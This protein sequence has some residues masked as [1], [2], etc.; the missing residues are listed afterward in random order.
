MIILGALAGSGFM[1]LTNKFT[2]EV[3][4]KDYISEKEI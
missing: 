2:D 3:K 4:V 1:I